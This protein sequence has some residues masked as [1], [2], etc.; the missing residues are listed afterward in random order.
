[1]LFWLDDTHELADDETLTAEW[2]FVG[3]VKKGDYHK[4]MNGENYYEW[5][6]KRLIP[7]FQEAFGDPTKT[8]M[9]LVLDSAPFHHCRGDEFID[10]KS[11]KR[12]ELFSE[13][14][15]TAQ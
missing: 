5:V 8:K 3:K 9:I 6:K 14:S 1:M 4:N 12:A 13:L 15:H 7:T 11:L 2:V 10:P